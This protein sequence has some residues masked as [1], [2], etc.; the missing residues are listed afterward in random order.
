MYYT[1][2]A[3]KNY[4]TVEQKFIKVLESIKIEGGLDDENKYSFLVKSE[5]FEC[6]KPYLKWLVKDPDI[7]FIFRSKWR[8]IH[9]YDRG[10]NAA[11]LLFVQY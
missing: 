8:L 4:R 1:K 9:G 2:K 6:E 10:T 5:D 11:L 7:H 3:M